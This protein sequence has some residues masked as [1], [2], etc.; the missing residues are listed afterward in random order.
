[1]IDLLE[2]LKHGIRSKTAAETEVLAGRLVTYLP[3]DAVLALHGDLGAGKTTFVRGL[4]RAWNIEEAVTSPTFN[5]YTIYHG[6]RQLI[7][8]DAYRL[9]SGADLDALM[10]EDFLKSP[11]CF[12]VEWPERIPDALPEDTWHLYLTINDDQ[13]H[14]IQLR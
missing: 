7:H 11:W 3:A 14:Q 5:L 10:I 4:A 1:M 6:D 13:S 2:Q 8:L 9:E 12:A